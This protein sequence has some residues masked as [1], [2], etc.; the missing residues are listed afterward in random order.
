MLFNEYLNSREDQNLF[1][2]SDIPMKLLSEQV[3]I[4]EGLKYHLE[5]NLSL[6]NTVYRYGSDAYY[7]L[8]NEVR[9][10]H[11][12]GILEINDHDRFFVDSDLGLEAVY[13]GKTVKLD[14]PMRSSGPKKYQVFVSSGRKNAQGQ[15]IAKKVT[16]GDRSLSVKNYSDARRKIGRA[17]V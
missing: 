5:N 3:Q 2:Q 1:E 10:L 6:A 11:N 12:N 9:F 13:H 16:F 17:H 4:S 15:M 8:V 14:S 7:N